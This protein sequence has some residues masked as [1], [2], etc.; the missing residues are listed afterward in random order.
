MT[1]CA[2]F[3]SRQ[4]TRVRLNQTTF[5]S[6]ARDQKGKLT[7]GE[8]FPGEIDAVIPFASILAIIEPHHPKAGNGTQPMPMEQ[9]LRIDF[10]Q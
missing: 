6:A 7:R 3:S 5:A 2:G 10:M 4:G 1:R 9:I 8:R